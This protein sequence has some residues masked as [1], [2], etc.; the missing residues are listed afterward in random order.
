M[1]FDHV[2]NISG[3]P[4]LV[5]EFLFQ[6]TETLT[7]GDLVNINAGEI[8]LA[9]TDDANL[10]GAFQGAAN[11]EDEDPAGQVAGT[12]S[13]TRGLAII[14][15]DAVYAVV[16]ANARNAGD[17][18]DLAGATG[19]MTVAANANTDLTVVRSKR[20]ATDLTLVKIA[21]NEHFLD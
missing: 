12:D 9:A 7:K 2:F 14:N 15:P 5:E 3:G 20:A 21:V 4:P 11:P 1:P 10:A 6:D 13:V 19:A 18:L 17:P 8:D 16:D